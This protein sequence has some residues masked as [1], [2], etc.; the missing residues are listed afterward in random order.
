MKQESYKKRN[1]SSVRRQTEDTILSG[2]LADK[3]NF[4]NQDEINN[5]QKAPIFDTLCK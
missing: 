4:L 2:V 1:T 5:L 3:D